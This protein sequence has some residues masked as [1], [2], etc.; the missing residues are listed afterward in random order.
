MSKRRKG[1]NTPVQRGQKER[2]RERDR[3]ITA[4]STESSISKL[5]C[6]SYFTV[7]VECK[8]ENEIG[9]PIDY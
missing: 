7:L 4:Q 6:S 5:V 3:G 9:V 2:E 8:C 1:Q